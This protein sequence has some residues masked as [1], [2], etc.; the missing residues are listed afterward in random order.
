ME[1]DQQGEMERGEEEEDRGRTAV[2]MKRT[3]FSISLICDQTQSPSPDC[4]L[5]EGIVLT[6]ILILFYYFASLFTTPL[7]EAESETG[8][9]TKGKEHFSVTKTFKW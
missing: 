2:H 7:L 9:N 1:G 6:V 5:S 3:A 8:S 4:K